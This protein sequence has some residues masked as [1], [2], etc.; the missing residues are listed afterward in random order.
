MVDINNTDS[1]WVDV[2]PEK[3]DMILE[4]SSVMNDKIIAKYLVNASDSLQ[5]YDMGLNSDNK[6]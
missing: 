4:S 1:Q 5:I 6:A 2:L 3:K